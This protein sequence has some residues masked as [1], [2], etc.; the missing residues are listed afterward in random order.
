VTGTSVPEL[1]AGVLE[2]LEQYAATFA[3]DFGLITR[4]RWAGVYLQ[5]L[6][7]DGERKSIEPLSRRVR[8]PGWH[9]DTEQALQQ[10]INQSPWDHQAVL[11][12]YRRVLAA[13]FADPAGVIV[14][15]DTG[16]A[17]KGVHS[18]GVARQ[19]SGTLGK[20]DNCQVA[21]SLHYAAPGGDYPLTL[22]LYLPE[23]WTDA[24]DRLAEAGV[25][26]AERAFATK[27]ELALHLLDQVRAEG[28]P[29]AGVVADAGYGPSAELRAGLEA[30]GER[31]VVGLTGEEVVLRAPPTW[32]VRPAPASCKG[33]KPQR[34]YLRPETPTPVAVQALAQTLERTH[35]RW[36]EGA[37]GPLA[38]EFAWVRIWPTPRWQ[39]GRA[40]ADVPNPS[41]EGRWLLVD[42]RA[43]GSVKYAISN[44]PEE[45]SLADAVTLWKQRWQVEQGYQ[46]L[47]EE[48]GL[49]HFEGRSWAGFHHHA[50]LTLLAYGFLALERQRSTAAVAAETED[51]TT[52]PPFRRAGRQRRERSGD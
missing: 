13:G 35:L 23:S 4:T 26:V 41:S 39:N 2:R 22:R 19:Y 21:V 11:R 36:R 42:W 44:L 1:D 31:Y 3:R 51:A 10:L 43:D 20:R 32:A 30:R 33:P 15:D 34:W 46:Q 12:T 14:I 45:A 17:K 16:F 29:H 40:A 28:L 48:L 52:L 38:G 27:P 50:A 24:P 25:P 7:L 6:L 5:G 9:G 8:T 18:V 49:D 37:K 47:K